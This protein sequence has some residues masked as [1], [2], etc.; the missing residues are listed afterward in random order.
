MVAQIKAWGAV[1]ALL[2]ALCILVLAIKNQKK[3]SALGGLLLLMTLTA[4]ALKMNLPPLLPGD[5]LHI[6]M[7]LS[8]LVLWMDSK[9]SV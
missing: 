9:R 4:F 1:C 6:G 3:L 8:L 5:L 7:S 2:S